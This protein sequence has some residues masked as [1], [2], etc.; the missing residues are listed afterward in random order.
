MINK[1]F[2]PV[3]LGMYYDAPIKENDD[4]SITVGDFNFSLSG[5]TYT[6]NG[7]TFQMEIGDTLYITTN[8]IKKYKSGE[9]P[10]SDDLFPNNSAHWLVTRVDDD[11]FNSLEVQ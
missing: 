9:Y 3:G 7:N 6:V 5:I 1:S 10:I 8:G 4:K 11:V 2:F